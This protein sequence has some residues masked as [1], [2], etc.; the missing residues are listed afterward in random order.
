LTK[1]AAARK[2]WKK[3]DRP[4]LLFEGGKVMDELNKIKRLLDEYFVPQD[5]WIGSNSTADRVEWALKR[6]KIKENQASIRFDMF[7][8]EF[9]ILAVVNNY[10]KEDLTIDEITKRSGLDPEIVKTTTEYLAQKGLIFEYSDGLKGMMYG[11]RDE[12]IAK[13]QRT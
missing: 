11:V 5:V 4:P 1:G 10:A 13:S 8:D 3:K 12:Q 7:S 6:K 2:N 9:I